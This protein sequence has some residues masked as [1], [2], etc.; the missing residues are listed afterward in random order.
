MWLM[1]D[2]RLSRKEKDKIPQIYQKFRE[3][4]VV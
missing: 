1:P 3:K 4:G 2:S